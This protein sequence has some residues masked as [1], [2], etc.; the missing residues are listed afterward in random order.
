MLGIRISRELI[1]RKSRLLLVGLA[2]TVLLTALP[3]AS[4]AHA[5]SGSDGPLNISIADKQALGSGC[6]SYS[7]D[8]SVQLGSDPYLQSWSLQV[9]ARNTDYADAT[10]GSDYQ[11][12]DGD[13]YSTGDILI[14]D[15][16]DGAGIYELSAT[17]TVDDAYDAD[18]NLISTGGTYQALAR[19]AISI[20][21]R[22]KISTSHKAFAYKNAS[23]RHPHRYK[24]TGQICQRY[25]C[26]G[27]CKRKCIDIQ[28][29]SNRSNRYQHIKYVSIPTSTE[30]FTAYVN[31]KV[32]GRVRA[33][34]NANRFYLSSKSP[35]KALK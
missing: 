12:G 17:L 10:A 9:E 14:C 4:P 15:L 34:Y 24:V 31:V 29:R 16:T 35:S 6:N 22:V 2:S 28:F 5:H 30:K 33:V 21:T 26:G 1:V 23:R 32:P 19:G 13:A 27:Y 20:P 3:P 18:Y 7:Y 25:G 8:F 11:Y